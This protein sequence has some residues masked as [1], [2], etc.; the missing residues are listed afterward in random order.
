MELVLTYEGR[1]PAQRSDLEVIWDI[2]KSFDR[3]LRKVWGKAPFAV[4]KEWEEGTGSKP[5]Q[6]T[7]QQ[8]GHTFVP[9]YGKDVGV[10][11]DLNITL[12]TGMPPQ[13]AIINAGD[14]D[15]RI[16]RLIDGLRAPKDKGEMSKNLPATGRWHC[17]VEDDSAVLGLQARLG[18][19]LGNDD[20]AISFAIVRVRPVAM[21]VTMDNLEMLF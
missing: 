15:N 21:R 14:L 11:V 12:L 6:F 4:L 5:P 19:Y 2:R 20:P 8:G 10:G 9:L 16:K 1:I 13:Q 18:A 3:Q 17:L 7:R